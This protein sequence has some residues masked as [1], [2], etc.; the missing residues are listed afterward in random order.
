MVT[1][2][3]R[4]RVQPRRPSKVVL[5]RLTIQGLDQPHYIQGVCTVEETE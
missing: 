5:S 4:G 2:F 1:P 3:L